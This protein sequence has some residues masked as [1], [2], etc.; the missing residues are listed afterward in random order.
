MSAPP[1]R[2]ASR[3][4]DIEGFSIDRVARAAGTDPEVLRL[5]NLDT[6]VPPP[7]AVIGVTRAA[8]SRTD[9]NSY[10]PF[11]GLDDLRAA[12]ARHVTR[13]SGV[14]HDPDTQTVIT[15]GGTEGMFNA[16]LALVEPGDEVVVT[17]PTYAGMIHRVHLAGG[18]PRFVPFVVRAGRWTL[19]LQRFHDAVNERTRVVFLMN[20]SI[21]SGAV[22]TRED[23]EEV[24]RVCDGRGIWLL[25][26]AAM[27]R[28]LFG[29]REYIHP[30]S[31]GGLADRTITV[32]SVSKE[33][34]M[35]GWRVGWVAGPRRI[36][37][38][39]GLVG[40]YNVVT[41]VGLS[42][43][44]AVA[45]LTDPG[46][47]GVAE[48]VAEWERRCDT[49]QAEL[50]GLPFVRADGGWSLLLDTGR[51]GVDGVVASG[52]LLE[53]GRVAAT[54]MIHWGRENAGQYVR[55]VFSNEPPGRLAGLGER[56]ADALRP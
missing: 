22:L 28:I 52:R 49:V 2:P 51:M 25:Y 13:Q 27:E 18:V 19:D 7:R 41:P 56:V 32:G 38:R 17:D 15:A 10:L 24:A 29:G 40:I 11:F 46:G 8:V 55:I 16:L 42:Q 43:P 36:M 34:R 9:A 5:E 31:V 3:L 14:H 21:P 6:D 50:A 47:A 20:P 33:Y 35:I 39:I 54:P 23:W 53:R 44:G 45:A 48:A 26:N 37:D 12:A 30:A 4:D 1:P